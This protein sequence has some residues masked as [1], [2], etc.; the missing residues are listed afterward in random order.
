MKL[1]IPPPILILGY[2]N[3][4]R[5]DDGAGRR[6]A[7]KIAQQQWEGVL[8]LSLHQLTPELA[9]E[10]S[11][12]RAAIF[13]DAIAS[14]TAKVSV[15]T[16]K[17]EEI[18]GDFS[19]FTDPSSLLALAQALYGKAPPAWWVLVPGINFAMGEILSAV[20]EVGVAEAVAVVEQLI[21]C[22]FL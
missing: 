14:D 17:P 5:S 21:E 2:G 11:Q 16:L 10:L 19:H 13:V 20:A 4:L 18:G 22:K 12:A 3:S 8:S 9:E 7:E 15:K 1:V 6:V